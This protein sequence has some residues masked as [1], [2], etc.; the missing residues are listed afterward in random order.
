MRF[1]KYQNYWKLTQS[2]CKSHILHTRMCMWDYTRKLFSYFL[3]YDE[4]ECL[5]RAIL[6]KGYFYYD[7]LPK[8]HSKDEKPHKLSFIFSSSQPK[9]F[10]VWLL[11]FNTFTALCVNILT[12]PQLSQAI[13]KRGKSSHHTSVWQILGM[14][15]M[16]D[17]NQKG[18]PERRSIFHHAMLNS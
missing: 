16:I 5:L 6:L 8:W 18:I 9:A 14:H 7:R 10:H 4:H 13:S 3:S 15:L 17:W 11:C 1:L 12:K 2:C